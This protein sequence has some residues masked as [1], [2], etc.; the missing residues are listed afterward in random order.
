MV[1]IN[2]NKTPPY[3]NFVSLLSF[4]EKIYILEKDAKRENTEKTFS[5]NVASQGLSSWP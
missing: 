3:L 5:V 1:F 2:R 4:L